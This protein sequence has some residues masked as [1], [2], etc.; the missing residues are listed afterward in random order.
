V[1]AVSNDPLPPSSTEDDAAVLA[2]RAEL[3]AM[4]RT[5]VQAAWPEGMP[6]P[7]EAQKALDELVD[8]FVVFLVSGDPPAGEGGSGESL[9]A[10]RIYLNP[11]GFGGGNSRKL[12]NIGTNMKSALGRYARYVVAV[13]GLTALAPWLGALSLLAVAAD[14]W[15][16]AR[17]R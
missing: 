5:S 9:S 1:I 16:D 10:H 7:P 8:G 3:L 6:L 12:L 4:A 11:G 2:R 17:S 15:G 14:I 13:A